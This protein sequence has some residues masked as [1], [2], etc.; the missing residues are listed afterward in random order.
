MKIRFISLTKQEV[1]DTPPIITGKKIGQDQ[2]G[3]YRENAIIGYATIRRRFAASAIDLIICSFFYW[4]GLQVIATDYMQLGLPILNSQTIWPIFA[5]IWLYDA[6]FTS[7]D[8]QATPGMYLCSCR[9]TD[10]VGCKLSFSQASLRHIYQ[11]A[12]FFSAGLGLFTSL[13]SPYRQQLHDIMSESCVWQMAPRP[14]PKIL[15]FALVDTS[16]PT[17]IFNEEY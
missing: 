3:E 2:G 17:S 6:A 12:T 13:F 5:A 7:S 14:L 4:F 9:I 1:P 16:K 8:L 11:Y 15:K 10:Q